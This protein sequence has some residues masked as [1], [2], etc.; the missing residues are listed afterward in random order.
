[1][2]II[3]PL[4][5]TVMPRPYRWRGGIYLS[6]SIAVLVRHDPDGVRLQ[7]EHFL[8]HDVLPELDA[9]EVMDLVMP[10]PHPEYLVSG[11]AYSAHQADRTK[12]MVSVRVGNKRKDGLVFGDRY[13]LGNRMSDPQPFESMPLTWANSFGGKTVP[14]NPLGTGLDETDVN[15]TAAIRLP[16]L[17]S[18]TD[19]IQHRGQRVAPHN[20]GQIRPDWPSRLE[21]LGTCDEEWVNTVGTG[22]FDD[23]QFSAFNAAP[24]DQIWH[25]RDA[26][27]LGESFEFWNMHPEQHCWSGT[28]PSLHA[29]CFIQRGGAEHLD[30]V[31]LRPTTVWF[32]PHRTSYILLFHGQ[33]EI[34]EDDAVDIVGIM[35]AL[36]HDGRERSLDHYQHVYARRT[37]TDT[38]ALDAFRDG[39][40]MPA[41]ILAPWLEDLSLDKRPLMSKLA[42]RLQRDT[43]AYPLGG[44]IGPV[45]PVTLEAL[46]ETVEHH[47][48]THDE[49]MDRLERER[50]Q[51]FDEARREVEQT[52]FE[53]KAAILDALAGLSAPLDKLQLPQKGPPDLD[54]IFQSVR[55]AQARHAMRAALS[56]DPAQAAGVTPRQLYDYSKRGMKQLYL[57]SVHFQQGV[58][59]VGKHRALEIRE[60]VLKKYRLSKKLSDMDL[61]GADLS[62]MDL[63]GA[64]FSRTWLENADFTGANLSGAKFDE[65]VLARGTFVDC[66]LDGAT[67]TRTNIGEATFRNASFGSATLTK[68]ICEVRTVF[69]HCAFDTGV[70]EDCVIHHAELRDCA[71]K[72][73]KLQTL[74]FEY[75]SLSDVAISDSYLDKVGFERSS[76]DGLHIEGSVINASSASETRVRHWNLSGSVLTKCIFSDDVAL[77]DSLWTDTHMH[78]TMFRAIGFENVVFDACQLEQCDFSQGRFVN[79]RFKK[80]A[81]PQSLFVRANL[82]MVDMSGCNWMQTNFQKA[83]LVG[84]NLSDCNFFRADMSETLL[85]ASTRVEGAYVRRTRLAPYRNHAT[86]RLGGMS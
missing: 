79:C 11:H 76:I 20:F 4:R 57:Y 74:T 14:E 24:D 2:K 61:T 30:E 16:N 86:A 37:S 25:D 32:L 65:T 35:G 45:K 1:M 55:T 17:E 56:S 7:A 34:V 77:A 22:F 64:D 5:M 36:E 50:R 60:Q 29:R 80:V 71:M 10:K 47:Q 72:N 43:G 42:D 9:D 58:A 83:S 12:C 46:A 70:I 85:D 26:L 63:S 84:A 31:P 68:L 41:D 27:G 23:L 54:A 15:G 66:R 73:M 8:V 82:D 13:W 21:K 81:A 52:S 49:M 28:L 38:A 39:D 53:N 59:R 18:P 62:G 48:K 69:D 40:L 51:A 75:L 6:V 44:F 78:Q 3:K 67:F 19:R 33:T